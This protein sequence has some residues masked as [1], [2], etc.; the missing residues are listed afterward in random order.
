M[1]EFHWLDILALA[2]FLLCWFGYVWS[3]DHTRLHKQSVS[4][5]MGY[6][7]QLWMRNMVGRDP[8]MLD[9]ITQGNLLYG[10]AF[11]A[12][13]SIFIIGGLLAMLGATDKAIAVLQALPFTE[14]ASKTLW[15]IK[16]LLLV[17]IFIYA[18]FKF[19]WCYRL[20]NYCSI[21]IGAAPLE[22]EATPDS[23]RFADHIAQLHG[24]AASHFNSGLRAYFFALAAL[25]WFLHPILFLA[26]STW[27]TLILYRREFRSRSWHLLQ[28]ARPDQSAD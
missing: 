11:Y 15:E 28:S 2:W 6:Y 27:V 4:A 12:S 25:S 18:F 8:R 1:I 13:T 20:F 21:M 16:V 14:T 22:T 7:R 10:V 23:T 5:V 26:A 17:I 24:L 9:A 19:A 3:V